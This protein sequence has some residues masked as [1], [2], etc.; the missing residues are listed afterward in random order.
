MPKKDGSKAK[1]RSHRR[2]LVAVEQ[3]EIKDL[4][5]RAKEVCPRPTLELR[6]DVHV[7]GGWCGDVGV[8]G[9]G[10]GG[11]GAGVRYV[12]TVPGMHVRN[13]SGWRTD[14][15]SLLPLPPTTW[16]SPKTC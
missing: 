6:I 15:H 7:A 5:K 14:H 11:V 10:E 16:T 2:N 12:Q 3:A 8:G 13:T 4:T 1:G 9:R